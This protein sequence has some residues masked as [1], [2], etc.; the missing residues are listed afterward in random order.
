MLLLS[1]VACLFGSNLSGVR[2]A[3]FRAAET[4]S[5]SAACCQNGALRVG[6][7]NERVVKC[8]QNVHLPG[9]D[10]A[11]D[12]LFLCSRRRSGR[13]WCGGFWCWGRCCGFFC[14]IY[15]LI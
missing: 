3:L 2:S 15:I 12:F 9:R 11:L 6:K 1:G 8:S 5:A 10:A 14:H 13:G 7:S 4:A